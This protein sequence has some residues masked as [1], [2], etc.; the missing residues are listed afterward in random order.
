M[1]RDP[2]PLMK[3]ET[4][5]EYLARIGACVKA[6]VWARQR[7]PSGPAT[8]TLPEAWTEC[9]NASWLRW[10]VLRHIEHGNPR[11][12]AAL[13]HVSGS[14]GGHRRVAPGG[15]LSLRPER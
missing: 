3:S 10:L 1:A 12:R 9:D 6:V 7:Y 14:R 13:V 5:P 2:T 8:R 4:L 15:R 11:T